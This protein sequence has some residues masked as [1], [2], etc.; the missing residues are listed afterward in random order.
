MGNSLGQ[1][2]IQELIQEKDKYSITYM[3]NIK[4]N[5]NEL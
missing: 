4:N 3:Q 1:Y 2:K 5:A